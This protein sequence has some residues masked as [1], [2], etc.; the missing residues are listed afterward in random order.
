MPKAEDLPHQLQ[1][2]ASLQAVVMSHDHWDD[3]MQEL[4]LA[5]DNLAVGP[6]LA[7]QYEAAKLKLKQGYWEES[8]SDFKA[9]ESVKPGYENIV[10]ILPPLLQLEQRL[11]DTGP[12]THRWQQ[13]ALKYP[14]P[15]ILA[16]TLTPHML[17]SAFNYIF[18][19]QVIV[20]PMKLRGVEQAK[21][22]F[23]LYAIS[24]NTV[25][26]FFG[27]VI[28]IALVR[29]VT[30]GLLELSS[31]FSIS[32]DKLIYLRTRCI[33]LG[34][35]IA[36]IGLSMWIAAGPIYPILIG[37]L[38]VRDYVFFIISLA[39]SGLAVAAYPFMVV[40]WL[41]T[42]IFYRP[43][44][45]PGSVSDIDITLLER[46]DRWKW[47]YFLLAGALPMLVISLGF[48]LG[49]LHSS[50]QSVSAL[51]GI[52]GL[53]GLAGFFMTLMLFKAIQNDLDLLRHLL[54]ACGSKQNRHSSKH[55]W[56]P[57]S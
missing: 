17:A 48:I 56:P 27:I 45:C 3:D 7:R 47:T 19:W 50:P 8:L 35:L 37:A 18:N 32:P 23:T 29:P 9:I 33:R 5:I 30:K 57:G 22:L 51:L 20:H 24:V 28:L 41:C 39:I 44:V 1:A 34:H 52:V 46:V 14:I 16:A 10:E 25:L 38:E 49:P 4:I 40:T 12:S 53:A 43:L 21:S 36:V 26:F 15:L 54:W 55:D 13:F 31:G 6:R 11:I 2:L 42:H